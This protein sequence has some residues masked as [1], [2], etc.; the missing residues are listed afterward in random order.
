M[1]IQAILDL[2]KNVLFLVFG[3]ISLPQMPEQI[4]NA[5]NTF[6]DL[7][8]DNV[9]LLGLFIRI[10]T[11]KLVVPVILIIMNFEKLYHLTLWILKKIPMLNIK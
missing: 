4:T 5:I 9:G 2:V 1:I 6:L 3:W 8:F 11:I 10:D 7:I